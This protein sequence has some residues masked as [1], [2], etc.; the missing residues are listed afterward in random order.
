MISKEYVYIA[1][2]AVQLFPNISP[3][4]NEAVRKSE[5]TEVNGVPGKVVSIE[6]LV[7]LL[8]TSF[9][10]KDKIKI[11]ELIGRVNKSVLY[12]ILGRFDDGERTLSRRLERILE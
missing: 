1:N 2:I 12:D 7:V 5:P 6:Y 10:T 9:R 4:F 11:A 8:L 3:L